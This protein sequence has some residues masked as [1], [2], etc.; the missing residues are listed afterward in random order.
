MYFFEN[1][2]S[3]F[4]KMECCVSLVSLP[5]VH[6]CYLGYEVNGKWHAKKQSCSF[7]TLFSYHRH[8]YNM[9]ANATRINSFH[10]SFAILRTSQ[11]NSKR[12]WQQ[13]KKWIWILNLLCSESHDDDNDAG[14]DDDAMTTSKQGNHLSS[15][16]DHVLTQCNYK[17]CNCITSASS[18]FSNKYLFST[19]FVGLVTGK[20][21]SKKPEWLTMFPCDCFGISQ[22]ILNIQT[23]ESCSFVRLSFVIWSN[24]IFL[25][26]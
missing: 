9:N 4:A 12:C 26:V 24:A 1:L 10:S 7:S 22:S 21:N 8:H 5:H 19:Y 11:V 23:F 16:S 17:I 25:T 6:P 18:Q 2:L 14:G 3:F 13:H 20:C 15:I